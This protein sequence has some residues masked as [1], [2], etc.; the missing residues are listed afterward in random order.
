MFLDFGLS[1]GIGVSEVAHGFGVVAVDLVA[2]V[3]VIAFALMLA[4]SRI[5]TLDG[6]MIRI[7]MS[8][9]SMPKKDV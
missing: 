2:G 5:I 8:V 7:S 1:N 3:G 6:F 9:Y 4:E